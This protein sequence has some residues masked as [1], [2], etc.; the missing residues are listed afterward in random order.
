MGKKALNV[1]SLLSR[2]LHDDRAKEVVK[3]LLGVN[4]DGFNRAL[5]VVESKIQAPYRTTQKVDVLKS[6]VLTV[7]DAWSVKGK[8]YLM[9]GGR[10][11]LFF[12]ETTF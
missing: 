10:C 3:Q 4:S 9:A 12:S 11:Q 5:Q 1:S 7:E 2:R 6:R 8:S